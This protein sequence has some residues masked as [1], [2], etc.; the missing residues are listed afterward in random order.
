LHAQKDGP[1]CSA[2][3]FDELA[4]S[5]HGVSDGALEVSMV[6]AVEP[7]LVAAAW[8]HFHSLRHTCASMLFDGG[9]NIKQVAVWLGHTD[10]A[11]TLRTYVDLMDQ[12]LD[13][14]DFLDAT[15]AVTTERVEADVSSTCPGT[16][17]T[18]QLA[19]GLGRSCA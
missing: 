12:G 17:A 2:R 6:L 1:G 14:A 8:V 9:K 13:G 3:I 18:R 7:V 11:F 10:P 15:V 4:R 19:Q 16:P 5:A